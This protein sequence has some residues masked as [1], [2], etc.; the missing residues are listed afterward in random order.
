MRGLAF[1][2]LA[3]CAPAYAAPGT[4]SSPA[5]T[6]TDSGTGDPA[7]GFELWSGCDLVA[8]TRTSL[9]GPFASNDTISVTCDDQVATPAYCI[10]AVDAEGDVSGFDHIYQYTPS[11]AIPPGVPVIDVTSC[12]EPTPGVRVC[13]LQFQ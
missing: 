11:S 5:I 10:V 7:T 9:V 2:L 8:Q 12:P 1:L 3:A 6:V 4:C 13:A